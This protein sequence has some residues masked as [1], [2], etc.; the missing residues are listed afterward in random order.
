[1][2][3]GSQ[4]DEYRTKTLEELVENTRKALKNASDP[5]STLK[6]IDNAQRLG[7]SHRFEEEIDTQLERFSDHWINAVDHEDLF[8]T[9]LLFRLLRHNGKPANSGNQLIAN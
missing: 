2:V 8:V 9:S 3:L 7:V 4:V 1:M 6:L 5:T